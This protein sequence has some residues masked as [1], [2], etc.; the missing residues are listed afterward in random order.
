M[1]WTKSPA[2]DGRKNPCVCCPP[3]PAQLHPEDI[4]AVGFGSA[5]VSR[6]GDMMLDGKRASQHEDRWITMA[7]AEALATVD[8]DHDWQIVLHGPLHGETYQRHGDGE[9]N[10]IEKNQG[11]A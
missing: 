11:F 8:P 4:I 1:T 2:L 6:D 3:I 10:L 7:D 5:Y 9:W